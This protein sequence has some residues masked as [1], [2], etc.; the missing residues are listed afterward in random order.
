MQEDQVHFISP[1]AGCALTLFGEG[2]LKWRVFTV[3]LYVSYNA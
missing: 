1:L 2:T 3:C